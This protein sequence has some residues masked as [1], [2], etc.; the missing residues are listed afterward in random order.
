MG[1]KVSG[2]FEDKNRIREWAAV[3]KDAHQISDLIGVEA[4]YIEKFLAAE[5]GAPEMRQAEMPEM[6]D[7]EEDDATIE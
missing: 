2:N 6:E 7:G 5:S 3:G 4:D 1:K